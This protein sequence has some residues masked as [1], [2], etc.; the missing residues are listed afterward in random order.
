VSRLPRHLE[1]LKTGF[2]AEA[3]AAARYRAYATR[4][5]SDGLP[6]LA[7]HWRELAAAK[8]ELAVALLATAGQ[9]RGA[10][11]DLGAA[12]AEESYENAVLYPKMIAQVDGEVAAAFEATVNVRKEHLAHL[13]KLRGAYNASQGDVGPPAGG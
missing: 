12:I 1:Y 3:V 4:A 5:D 6:N 8:D 10:A 2:T 11:R 13:E 7:R 9:V